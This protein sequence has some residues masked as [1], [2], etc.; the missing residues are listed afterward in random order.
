MRSGAYWP[1]LFPALPG[2]MNFLSFR[3][4]QRGSHPF[5]VH[6]DGWF[7]L[8]RASSMDFLT[9]VYRS[10]TPYCFG[11][12]DDRKLVAVLPIKAPEIV[13]HGGRWYI[14]DLADFQGVMLHRLRWEPAENTSAD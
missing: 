2:S 1:L 8:F 13:R 9:Y 14:S 7:Y 11:C 5:V 3:Q 4:S 10:E 6:L 12:N